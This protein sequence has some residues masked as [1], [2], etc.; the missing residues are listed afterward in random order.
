MYVSM[1]R[2]SFESEVDFILKDTDENDQLGVTY[3]VQ[4]SGW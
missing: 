3:T 4:C 1:G 2:L